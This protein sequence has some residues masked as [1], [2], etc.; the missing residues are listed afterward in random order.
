M[1]NYV[2]LETNQLSQTFFIKVITYKI[3]EIFNYMS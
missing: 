1:S 2:L 3:I